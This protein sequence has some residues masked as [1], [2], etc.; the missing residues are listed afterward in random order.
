M[1]VPVHIVHVAVDDVTFIDNVIEHLACKGIVVRNENWPKSVCETTVVRKP[2]ASLDPDR[3]EKIPFS[4]DTPD[5]SPALSVVWE[6]IK[7]LQNI[8]CLSREKKCHPLKIITLYVYTS[9]CVYVCVCACVCDV[10]KTGINIY[11]RKSA[12]GG[13]TGSRFISSSAATPPRVTH[14][15]YRLYSPPHSTQI[16]A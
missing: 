13:H 7:F 4:L 3:A 9:V 6:M 11:D 8:R 2:Q 12:G 14:P 16:S 15:F 10:R 5:S 1:C